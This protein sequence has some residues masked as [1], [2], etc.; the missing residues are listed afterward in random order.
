MKPMKI[1]TGAKTRRI[2]ASQANS[3]ELFRFNRSITPN[4]ETLSKLNIR[5]NKKGYRIAKIYQDT[6]NNG[7]VERKELIYA[8]KSRDIFKD[9]ELTDF[10]GSIRIE[11]TMH[12]CDWLSM[13]YWRKPLMCTREYIPITYDVRLT[14]QDGDRHEFHSFGKFKDKNFFA[15]HDPNP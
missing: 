13:K 4:G 7:K 3:T 14:T 6:N 10:S 15:M 5:K 2:R 11:K 9:D 1:G 12:M 8:G